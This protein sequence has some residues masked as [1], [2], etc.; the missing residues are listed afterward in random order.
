MAYTY[1]NDP[2][3]SGTAAQQRDAVRFLSQDNVLIG[4][5]YRSTDEEIA[6]LIAT[7]ANIYMAA[8]RLCQILAQR[9]GGLTRKRVGDLELEFGTRQDFL[10][11][12]DRLFARGMTH[13]IPTVG[14]ISAADK[15]IL[16]SDADWLRPIFSRKMQEN[17]GTTTG[18]DE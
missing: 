3:V 18:A 4:A 13:Q 9:G 12:A 2:A 11:L 16:T 5:V 17:V 8:G 15:E 1:S 14:G 7:E 10:D 6:F